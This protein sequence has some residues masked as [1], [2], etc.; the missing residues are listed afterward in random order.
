MGAYSRWEQIRGWALIQI[1]TVHKWNII[2]GS[3]SLLECFSVLCRVN[4][5][6]LKNN[7]E[8][9]QSTAGNSATLIQ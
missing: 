4:P 7:K 8:A 3:V 5:K 6:K 1:N 9:C 2:Y